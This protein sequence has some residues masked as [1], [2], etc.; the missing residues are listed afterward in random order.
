[1]RSVALLQAFRILRTPRPYQTWPPLIDIMKGLP[2]S[3]WPDDFDPGEA[4]RIQQQLPVVEKFAAHFA[5]AAVPCTFELAGSPRHRFFAEL[6][7]EHL[8]V[9]SSALQGEVTLFAKVQRLI[10]KG[11]PET[12]GTGLFPEAAL[13]REQRRKQ[14]SDQPFTVRLSYPAAVVTAIAIYR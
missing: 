7:R 2:R 3:M 10:R 5:D 12:L 6:P 8:L 9:E 4:D 11:S 1:M 14:K 13:N